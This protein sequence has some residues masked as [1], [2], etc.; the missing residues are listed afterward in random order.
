[1]DAEHAPQSSSPKIRS[2]VPRTHRLGSLDPYTVHTHGITRSRKATATAVPRAARPNA[3]RAISSTAAHR[4]ANVADR[5]G[6]PL[7]SR[8]SQRRGGRPGHAT[9][10]D[11]DA[12]R[13]A[14]APPA[15]QR[16]AHPGRQKRAAGHPEHRCTVL[17][18]DRIRDEVRC[19][20]QRPGKVMRRT[21]ALR[22]PTDP[23][24][25]L[26]RCPGAELG[27]R[28]GTEASWPDISVRGRAFACLSRPARGS[29]RSSRPAHL[30]SPGRQ[31]TV[32]RPE[33]DGRRTTDE[34]F[35]AETD[36]TG[37]GREDHRPG[38]A[39]TSTEPVRRAR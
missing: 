26:P 30:V 10:Q 18:P 2:H 38:P 13:P 29:G 1:M 28:G 9:R 27:L 4:E 5:F 31:H 25:F 36:T 16:A 3:A 34:L 14:L 37:L 23:R 35:R 11:T 12:G 32:P 17:R 8:A 22:Q 20:W 33:H 21:N 15:A 6:T 39:T 7:Q 24:V 19:V